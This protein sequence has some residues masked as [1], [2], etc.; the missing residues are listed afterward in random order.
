MVANLADLMEQLCQESSPDLTPKLVFL[1]AV[2]DRLC[3]KLYRTESCCG[4]ITTQCEAVKLN[5]LT[6]V[7]NM[8]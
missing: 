1:T 8:A 7:R 4:V 2:M 6:N 5:E 3:R